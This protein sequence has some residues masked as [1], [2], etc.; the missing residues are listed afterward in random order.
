M[1]RSNTPYQTS[2]RGAVIEAG[3]D[4]AL[5]CV[6]C[7]F[8]YECVKK[9]IL[10]FQDVGVFFFFTFIKNHLLIHKLWYMFGENS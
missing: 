8:V 10:W 3:V 2:Q 9:I 1:S 5:V 4:E 6:I 7:V